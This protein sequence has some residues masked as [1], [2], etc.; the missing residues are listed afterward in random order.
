VALRELGDLLAKNHLRAIKVFEG[1]RS[2]LA[3]T[4]AE[5]AA[6]RLAAQLEV[7]D[8]PG[9]SQTLRDIVA[10]RATSPVAG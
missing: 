9:A 10:L 8:F 2:S 7:F 1:V 4:D 5:D 6:T 3:G